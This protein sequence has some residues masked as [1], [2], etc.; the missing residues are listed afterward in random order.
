MSKETAD[1]VISFIRKKA[2]NNPMLECISIN[3][4]GGEPLMNI[5]MLEYICN[6]V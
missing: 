3:G 5:D 4:F 6:K 1:A 2:E